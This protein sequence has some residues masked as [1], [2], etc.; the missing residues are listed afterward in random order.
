[1]CRLFFHFRLNFFLIAP[2]LLISGWSALWKRRNFHNLDKIKGEMC[3][4]QKKD[5]LRKFYTQKRTQFHFGEKKK[6]KWKFRRV[7]P[8]RPISCLYMYYI[9][10]G[11]V[12]GWHIRMGDKFVIISIFS[13]FREFIFRVK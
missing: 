2:V 1:M 10:I 4:T 5:I 9:E 8:S 11:F 12:N 6:K 7:C 13:F 3:S